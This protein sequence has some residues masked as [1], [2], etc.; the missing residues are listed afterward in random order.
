MTYLWKRAPR[1]KPAAARVG[2]H[3]QSKSA[4][5]ILLPPLWGKV[6]PPGPR[7]ARP[8]GKLRDGRGVPASR[9]ALACG[10]Y[11]C[12][13]QRARCRCRPHH[14]GAE[15]RHGRLVHDPNRRS[16][17]AAR[18]ANLREALSGHE[19]HVVAH[20]CDD[21]GDQDPERKSCRK[22][23][24][25]RFRRYRHG[26]APEEG[27][28]CHAVAARHG[29]GLPA[30]IQGQGRLLD[31]HEFLCPDAGLQHRDD[32]ARDRTEDV[33]G[34]ARSEMAPDLSARFWPRWARTRA[35]PI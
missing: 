29:E 25:R 17:R 19:G 12:R 27:G 3:A 14:S 28:L 10:G 6:S 9:V 24:V 16:S 15:G 8:K 21:G 2:D 13:R 35:S 18:G 33:P 20:Q 22:K 31:R 32:S 7:G 5:K 4:L 23:S 34:A 30:A 26:R 1:S 11:F